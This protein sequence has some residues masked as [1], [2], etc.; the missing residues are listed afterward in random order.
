M[1]WFITLRFWD[2]E[3]KL[4]KKQSVCLWC[5]LRLNKHAR[6][7]SLAA[8]TVNKKSE[9]MCGEVSRSIRIQ[10]MMLHARSAH[11]EF[12]TLQ[13]A[14][15]WVKRTFND[16]T[17]SCCTVIPPVTCTVHFL[18]SCSI[19]RSICLLNDDSLQPQKKDRCHIVAW[20][21]YACIC[22]LTNHFTAVSTAVPSPLSLSSICSLSHK[23]LWVKEE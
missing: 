9:E 17:D 1:I 3:V 10:K 23:K 8:P 13:S 20:G 11:S 18:D 12:L 19:L 14:V 4:N 6:L 16:K 22:H 5:W 7:P 15:F 21:L 2:G